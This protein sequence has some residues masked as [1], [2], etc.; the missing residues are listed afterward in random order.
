[1]K[2]R[3]RKQPHTKQTDERQAQQ[4]TTSSNYPQSYFWCKKETET[5]P[6]GI[7]KA[8]G[9]RGGESKG[10]LNKHRRNEEETIGVKYLMSYAEAKASSVD[11]EPMACC[12]HQCAAPGVVR[13]ANERADRLQSSP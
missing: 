11:I 13:E 5:L 4:R 2:R 12:V 8:P 10:H 6:Q 3:Q 9:D 1:M 7:L